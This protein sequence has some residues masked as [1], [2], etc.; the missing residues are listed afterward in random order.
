LAGSPIDPARLQLK[1]HFNPALDF[2]TQVCLTIDKENFLCKKSSY[3]KYKKKHELLENEFEVFRRVCQEQ[4]IKVTPQRFEIFKEIM[5]ATDHPS[6]EDIYKRVRDRLPSISLD[7]VY[8]TLTAL[9][10]YGIIAR[11]QIVDKTRFDPNLKIHHHLICSVCKSLT[12][13]YWPDFDDLTP[14]PGIAGW[15]HPETKHVQIMGICSKCSS[16][17]RIP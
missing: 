1:C 16:E 2:L 7:T 13:F 12:D 15:G 10:G 8:R 3:V 5:R 14:P 4:G 11:I 9:E 17:R 6:A